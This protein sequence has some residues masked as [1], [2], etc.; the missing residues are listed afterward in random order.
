MRA[1]KARTIHSAVSGCL[2]F[3]L[4]FS[5]SSVFWFVVWSWL[6]LFVPTVFCAELIRDGGIDL[7]E[8]WFGLKEQTK[9]T[10]KS[11]LKILDIWKFHIFALRWRDEI[12]RS[13]QLRTLLKR[14]VV[15]RTW[16][17]FRPA[18]ISKSE[19]VKSIDELHTND[20]NTDYSNSELWWWYI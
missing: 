12:R 1:S 2:L 9:L 10:Y 14:V 6:L 4:L 11:F 17:K 7:V 5:L 15:N 16:K 3:P 19:S 8:E 20:I 18:R 13:S